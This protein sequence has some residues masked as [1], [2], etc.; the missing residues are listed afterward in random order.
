MRRPVQSQAA[1]VSLQARHIQC[2]PQLGSAESSRSVFRLAPDGPERV[3]L[4]MPK[5]A[6]SLNR[7]GKPFLE[8]S[9]MKR[10]V[11]SIIVVFLTLAV[12]LPAFAR[13]QEAEAR[14]GVS[15]RGPEGFSAED[16]TQMISIQRM[17]L[18]NGVLIHPSFSLRIFSSKRAVSASS[19][20][21]WMTFLAQPWTAPIARGVKMR[22]E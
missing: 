18:S 10:H 21:R 7:N 1:S 9:K 3:Y 12:L 15:E 5:A 20:I 16:R 14:Q 13:A 22:R 4:Q 11:F 8:S 6:I 19:V 17:G 2:P